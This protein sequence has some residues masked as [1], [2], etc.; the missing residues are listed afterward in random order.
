[1]C[2]CVW[3]IPRW[4]KHVFALNKTKRHNKYLWNRWRGRGA[5]DRETCIMRFA[6]QLFA[7]GCIWVGGRC[8]IALSCGRNWIYWCSWKTCNIL[9]SSARH[10]LVFVAH[11][12]HVRQRS[13]GAYGWSPL[14][15][16]WQIADRNF[17]W[18]FP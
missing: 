5:A 3:G 2:F 6:W 12:A 11:V 9:W 7:C 10:V 13:N 4:G 16:F 17:R 15:A 18:I 8:F 1:L 14:A